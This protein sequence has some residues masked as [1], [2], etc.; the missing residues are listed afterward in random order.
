[1]D[2]QRA[3]DLLE[4]H[5]VDRPEGK[6]PRDSGSGCTVN[7]GELAE[8]VWR[9]YTERINPEAVVNAVAA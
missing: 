5:V 9:R 4:R 6:D 3:V 2:A 1:V 7:P 8:S